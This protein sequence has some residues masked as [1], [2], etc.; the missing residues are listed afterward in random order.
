MLTVIVKVQKVREVPV[1][2]GLV[3]ELMEYLASRGIGS[4]TESTPGLSA[5]QD[6]AGEVQRSGGSKRPRRSAARHRGDDAR[7]R[8]LEY[9]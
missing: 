7:K 3:N 9:S 2:T 6:R 1:P 5:W 4:E 8:A